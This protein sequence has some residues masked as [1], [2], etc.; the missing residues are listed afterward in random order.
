MVK[1]EENVKMGKFGNI[2]N[3]ERSF[4]PTAALHSPG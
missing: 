2:G 1:D 3:F 4:R